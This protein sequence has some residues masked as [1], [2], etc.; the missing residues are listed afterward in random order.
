MNVWTISWLVAF[1][2]TISCSQSFIP[3]IRIEDRSITG[4][5]GSC[6]E[7]RC[8]I[9]RH[10]ESDN[11]QLFWIKDPVWHGSHYTGTNIYSKDPSDPT[12]SSDFTDRVTYLGPTSWKLKDSSKCN[13]RIC[14]LKATDSGEYM[15][16][17]IKGTY[18]WSPTTLLLS[19]ED[20]PEHTRA[21]IS[22]SDITEGQTVTLT[23]STSWYSYPTLSWYK[24][25]Q[26]VYQSPVWRIPS[27]R[28][29][30]SGTYRCKATNT[31]RV[32]ESN[33]LTVDVK[34]LPD[35]EIQTT[36]LTSALKE[37]DRVTLECHVK[38][39]NPEPH[40]Y[41][42]LKNWQSIGW[43]Q[44]LSVDNIKPEDRGPYTCEATNRVGTGR[45]QPLQIKV[46]YGPRKSHIS[47]EG[48]NPRVQLGGRVG[49]VCNAD[50][51]PAAHRY[52]W[53]YNNTQEQLDSY[54]HSTLWLS[55]VERRHDGNYTCRATNSINTGEKSE[56]LLIKVLYPPTRLKLTM[57]T[58]VT[59][60]QLITVVCTVESF[61][62]STLTL[63][64]SYNL[65]RVTVARSSDFPPNELHHTF[66]ATSAEAGVYTCDAI[67]SE[68]SSTS[69][70]QEL[71]V[72]YRPKNVK[73]K[74]QPG[75]NV[76]ENQTLRLECSS[77]SNPSKTSVTWTK[78]SGGKDETVWRGNTFAISSVSLSDGGLYSCTATNDLGSEKS[79]QEEVKVQ[80]SPKH[81]E[82]MKSTNT[83]PDGTE[84][85]TLSCSSH[86]FPPV[87]SYHW[88]R[89]TEGESEDQLVS[90]HQNQTIRSDEPGS[91]YCI[92]TNRLGQKRSER[93]QLFLHR[94]FVQALPAIIMTLIALL[95]VSSICLVYRR[96]R[97]KSIQQGRLNPQP[98][99]RYFGFLGSQG[100]TPGGNLSESGRTEPFRS[101]DDL[102]PEHLCGPQ[103]GP[104]RR[105]ADKP[106]ASNVNA[107][108]ST[109]NLPPG[110]PI[111][112]QYGDIEDD[113]VKYASLHFGVKCRNAQIP[114]EC[115]DVVYAKV[116]KP[117]PRNK[118]EQTQKEDY[119]NL[120]GARAAKTPE[121]NN[122][123][124]TSEEE[125]DVNYSQVMFRAKPSPDRGN[126]DGDD[127]EEETQYTRVNI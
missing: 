31:W 106:S 51:Y 54:T 72:K 30:H 117:K 82:I 25:D 97:N 4:K 113:D 56:P 2:L 49:L 40:S 109:V 63:I 76:K 20:A 88:Y 36:P 59:E 58:E 83:E 9:T 42:F 90:V 35:V 94:G 7:I 62:P 108:Y 84:S 81:T 32:D 85:V 104:C 103:P 115:E 57:V 110:Q 75:L 120:R 21:K 8:T 3:P 112:Q 96:R 6:I 71:V 79:Q 119:E 26:E 33:P 70:K 95:V 77:E 61:P 91:Y 13:I 65:H 123:T 45:S 74:A 127:D 99:C 27:I 118:A 11:A 10:F 44:T 125:V 126:G 47:T 100:G 22:S 105:Q 14:S 12:V 52:S 28:A 41:R 121:Y 18:K 43:T 93:V 69:T 80:Y 23:C 116:S 50:A 78:T 24:D 5:V 98:C 107:I 17:Y 1:R 46:Q 66:N 86:S 68:G 15:L 92:S 67:N 53:Y 60:V 19:V 124:D 55:P 64:H 39:S 114:K 73:V 102:L 48:S 29:S 101:R 34:Y 38:R 89:V 122:E 16:R 37:G 87:S 111:R